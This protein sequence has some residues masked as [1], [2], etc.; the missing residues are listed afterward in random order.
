[1]KGKTVRKEPP[2]QK[3]RADIMERLDDLKESVNGVFDGYSENHNW[4]HKSCLWELSYA[5]ALILPHNIDLMH[6][7]WNIAESIMRM[8][9]DVTGFM[10]DN[11][12]GRKDLAALCDRL[13]LEAKPN[14]R[15]KLS[16]PMAPYC[17]RP[18]ERKEVLRWLKILKFPDCYAANIK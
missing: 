7:G 4:T 16:R 2:K 9:L 14:A 15:G 12:N 17:L 6:Q 10:K 1:L 11:M 3:L 13:L 5:K 18:T 8:C